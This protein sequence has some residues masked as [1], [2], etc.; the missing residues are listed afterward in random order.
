[1]KIVKW[2]K[3]WRYNRLLYR[4]IRDLNNLRMEDL[5]QISGYTDSLYSVRKYRQEKEVGQ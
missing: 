2:L 5:V 1:M 4:L 3:D